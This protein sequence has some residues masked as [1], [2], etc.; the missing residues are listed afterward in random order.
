MDNSTIAAIATPSGRGGI[1]IIKVSGAEAISIAA[2]IFRHR[3]RRLPAASKTSARHSGPGDIAFQSHRLYYGYIVDPADES[4]LDEVLL[5]VMK[6]PQTYTC[7][8]LVEI[9][10]HGGPVVLQSILALVLKH[11]ARLAEP[12]EFTQRAFLNGR[13]DLTQAEAVIDIVNARTEKSLQIA[14]AHAGGRLRKRVESIQQPLVRMLTR[15]EAGIDFPEDV[16]DLI[17]QTAVGEIR[18]KVV[19]PLEKL[20]RDYLDSHVLRDGLKV[21]VVGKPNVGKSSLM[22]RLV[23]KDRAIVTSIPGTT[24]DVIEE[25]LNIR[26]VPLVLSD[27]AGFHETDDPVESIGVEKTI[28]NANGSDLILFLTEANTPLSDEDYQLYDRIKGKPLIIVLNKIDL[29]CG[30]PAACVPERWTGYPGIRIS[31]LYGQGIDSLKDKIIETTRGDYPID[32]NETIVPN[33]R[34]KIALDKSL[35]AAKGA[36]AELKNGASTELVAINLKEAIDSLGEVIGTNVKLDIL[37]KVF[38]QFCI[39]K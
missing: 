38:S 23:E 30:K 7:E 16:E 11:G 34:Q 14:T 39:G 37:D 36:I 24:R 19:D 2:A 29:V 15:A 32:L 33:L 12:G 10:S 1:G 35:A 31:A 22:N 13:I 5:S 25:T 28:A 17:D 27:T 4:L 3:N 20:I 26:G 18:E 6:A 9:N 8:N 21:A